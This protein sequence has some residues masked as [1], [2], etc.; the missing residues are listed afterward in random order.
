MGNLPPLITVRDADPCLD[1]IQYAP[2]KMSFDRGQGL[3]LIT[4]SRLAWLSEG[5]TDW[6]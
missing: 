1:T 5:L 4:F 2:P 3:E 6:R